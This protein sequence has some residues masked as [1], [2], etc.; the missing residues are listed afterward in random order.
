MNDSNTTAGGYYESGIRASGSGL[1]TAT[2]IIN[3][4]FS[5]HVATH[6][7]Y[8]TNTVTNG[9]PSAGSWYD[10]SVELMSEIMVY[11][12]GIFK[13]V[14]DGT[15]IVADY[16]ISKS[17]LPLFALNPKLI[18]SSRYSWWLRDVVSAAKFAHVSNLGYADSRDASLARGVRPAFSIIG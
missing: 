6:R 17:Q 5:G 3:S 10:C 8:L 15:T 7:Q 4:A 11:G 18:V 14:S 2:T 13:P 9:K 1:A 12:C 16:T